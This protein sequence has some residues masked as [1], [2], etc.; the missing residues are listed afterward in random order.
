MKTYKRYPY[1]AH[2]AHLQL[3]RRVHI[4]RPPYSGH[5]GM[6]PLTGLG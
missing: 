3:V 2:G 4:G 6:I 5:E 1:L